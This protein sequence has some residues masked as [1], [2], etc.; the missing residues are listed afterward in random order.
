MSL[1]VC[2]FFSVLMSM[3]WFCRSEGELAHGAGA[4]VE[5]WGEQNQGGSLCAL[6]PL[7]TLCSSFFV[8]RSVCTWAVLHGVFLALARI[9]LLVCSLCFSRAQLPA[10][11][12][13]PLRAALPHPWSSQCITCMCFL[14]TLL[15]LTAWPVARV[16]VPLLR[17][18]FFFFFFN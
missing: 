6:S 16:S 15:L 12:A 11:T 5:C 18:N 1:A 7:P 13:S 3:L 8:L 17:C 10:W 4:G 14:L 2:G 9:A